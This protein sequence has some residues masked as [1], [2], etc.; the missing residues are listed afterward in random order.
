M[1]ERPN[2]IVLIF[3]SLRS[4]VLG[5]YGGTVETPAFDAVAEQG[6]VFESFFGTAPG[7]P[8]SHASL[9]SGQYPHEHGVTGQYITIRN[10]V[11][12]MAEWFRNAGYD[13]F[14]ITGPAKMGSDWGYDRGFNELFE[15]YHDKPSP[16]SW[17]NLLECVVDRRF[18]RYFFRQLTRG[19]RE[20]TR[21]KFE[22]L[23]DR[24]V[25]GL[26]R[27][28]FSVVNF[29]TVHWPYDPPRPFKRR[30]TPGFRRPRLYLTE[31]LLGDHGSVDDPDIRL[32]RV[33]NVQRGD[34]IGRYLADSGYL[35]EKEVTLLRTWYR[36]CVRHL[37]DQLGKFLDYYQRNLVDNTIL[38][39]TADHGEQLGEHGLWGHSH[40]F[41]D[42][43]LKIPLIFVGPDVPTGE[44][45]GDL[46]SQVDVFDTVCDLCGLD[47]PDET[48]GMSL[49]E[50]HRRDAVFMEYGERDPKDFATKTP[51]GRYLSRDQLELYCAGRKAI[52]TKDYRLEITSS[53]TM[54]LFELPHQQEVAEPADAVVSPLLAEL[55]ETVGEEYGVWPEGDPAEIKMDKQV[56]DHL[57]AMGYLE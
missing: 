27:P 48:S 17:K 47:P 21:Y 4:D 1:A 46:A 43:T 22:L 24:I 33:M 54:H 18:R 38:V 28:F 40:R 14:G 42:E 12:V 11:P 37:D 26:N 29:L 9:Y 13:T 8:V 57:R 2:V 41:Y 39:L 52:R 53:G 30:A 6:T 16:T 49:F 5:A 23:Q 32:D 15:Y 34:G 25:S 3:D 19:G 45:R 35:N 7:T 31:Y 56:E 10:D 51:Y 44:R 50:N 36:A 55:Q 20:K